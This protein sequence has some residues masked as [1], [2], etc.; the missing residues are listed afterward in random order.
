MNTN[1][2]VVM[3]ATLV[4]AS[5]YALGGASAAERKGYLVGLVT[6]NSR[7]WVADYRSANAELLDKYGGRILVRGAPATVLEGD[8][9]AADAILWSSSRP[10]PW[11]RRG[12]GT[13]TRTISH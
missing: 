8:A 10:C 2:L 13:A 3:T 7:D 1:P 4:M 5:A 12:R 6:V 9:P 11:T